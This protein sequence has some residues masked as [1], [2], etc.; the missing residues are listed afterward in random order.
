[1]QCVFLCH[2]TSR[3][4]ITYEFNYGILLVCG[5]TSKTDTT[6]GQT[7]ALVN[8]FTQNTKYSG[9]PAGA[10][11]SDGGGIYLHIT[12]AGKYWRLN[13]CFAGKQ[14]TLALGVYPAVAL[15]QAQQGRD[16][17][18]ELLAARHRP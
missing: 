8:T 14:K 5:D 2:A 4:T 3:N 1:M 11:D 10:K 7:V 15:A 13:Y 18:R 9:V 16:K 17:A 12:K 6:K